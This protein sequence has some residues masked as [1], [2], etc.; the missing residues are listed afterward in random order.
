MALTRDYESGFG[1]SLTDAYCRIV[2]ARIELAKDAS[3]NTTA[4]LQY[5]VFIYANEAARTEEKPHMESY[6][7]TMG[8]SL[9][10]S[11]NHYNII[12]QAYL[13]LKQEDEWDEAVDA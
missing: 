11:K 7:G 12:R 5:L 6:T 9:L 2:D 8:I 10:D 13:A 4:E 1:M 3:E